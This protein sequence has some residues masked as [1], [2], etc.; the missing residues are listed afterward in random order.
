MKFS[1]NSPQSI[2]R[3]EKSHFTVQK[4]VL[5]TAIKREKFSLF[6][7]EGIT[8]L[9]CAHSKNLMMFCRKNSLQF[10]LLLKLR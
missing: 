8:G 7:P 5:E 3:N 6:Y 9:Q 10:A 1:I 4:K 2:D